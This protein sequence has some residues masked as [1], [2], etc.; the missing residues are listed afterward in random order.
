MVCLFCCQSIL[1]PR[2]AR[3]ISPDDTISLLEPLHA[4]SYFMNKSGYIAAEDGGPLL[5]EDTVVLHVVVERIHSHSGVLHNNLAWTGGGHG[6]F[7]DLTGCRGCREVGCE[8]FD[9][10]HVE[11]RE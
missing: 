9:R 1:S 7:A 3:I 10:R 2:P 4:L 5:H 6:R 11:D 8:A